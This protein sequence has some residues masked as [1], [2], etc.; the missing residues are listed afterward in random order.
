MK[1]LKCHWLVALLILT[2]AAMSGIV[3][4]QWSGSQTIT[5]EPVGKGLGYQTLYT[6]VFDYSITNNWF[7]TFIVDI[8]PVKGTDI[9]ISTTYYLRLGNILYTTLWC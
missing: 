8:H 5:L 4:A 9:D 1:K 7:T 2:L 3:S 6:G